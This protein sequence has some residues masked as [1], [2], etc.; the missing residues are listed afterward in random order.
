MVRIAIVGSAGS[1]KSTLARKVAA[2]TGVHHIE[3]DAYNHQPG[4]RE[5]EPDLLRA[6]LAAELDG[7]DW[8]C[9]G[10]YDHLV[11]DLVRGAADTIVVFDLPRTLVARQ[12]A[13]RTLRRAVTREELWNGN[14]EPLSNLYRWDP[15]RNVIRWSWVHHE[16]YR[17]R[18]RA[19]IASG[20]WD[21]AQVVVLRSRADADA[22]LDTLPHKTP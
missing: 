4:W 9:D 2:R 21:H 3:I 18:F 20:E 7:D 13:W 6:R 15:E 8:L 1:G 14:R 11:G 22:W 12:I 17:Q 16:E 10:N 5:C 19:K